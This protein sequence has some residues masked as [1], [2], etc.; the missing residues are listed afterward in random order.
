[1]EQ[2]IDVVILSDRHVIDLTKPWHV[3]WWAKQ[4]G[5]SEELLQ[6]AV[7]LVGRRA[8]VVCLYLHRQR[9]SRVH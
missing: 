1:M 3:A 2:Q 7:V 4:F 9:K 5:V 6:A 8:D